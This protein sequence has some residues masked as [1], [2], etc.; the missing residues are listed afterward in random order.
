LLDSYS[1]SLHGYISYRGY[2]CRLM[3]CSLSP[4]SSKLVGLVFTLAT[5]VYKLQRVRLPFDGVLTVPCILKL[6]RVRLP[7]DGVLTVPCILKLQRVR[8]PFDGVLTVPCILK[9]QRV[10][11]P[12]DGLLDSY[13]PSLPGYISCRGSGGHTTVR[14]LSPA[15][16]KLAGLVSTLA[17]WVYKLQRVR[18]PF[19]GL[20]D[21]YALSLPVH[22][23]RGNYGGHLSVRSLSPASSNC[24]KYGGRFS[25]R[26]PTPASSEL[27]R[28]VF[29]FATHVY[30]LPRLRWPLILD[31]DMQLL[32]TML[33]WLSMAWGVLA[34]R[35]TT[36]A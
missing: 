35:A 22:I 18:L 31:K 25:V 6:Q 20:L 15:S 21:S 34:G 30:E 19:D 28:L 8:L 29:T 10:R 36:F 32:N 12:F 24:G 2:G 5:R 3:V 26:S 7:F 9:L 23:S 14:S 1:P 11:L 16:S 4:A 17:T 33:L 13:S 27:I